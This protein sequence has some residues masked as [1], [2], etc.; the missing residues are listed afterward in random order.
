MK[1]NELV[2]PTCG[3]KCL[4][5]ASYTTCD[6]CQTFF[7]ASQ[8]AGVKLPVKVD[9]VWPGGPF[10]QETPVQPLVNQPWTGTPYPYKSFTMGTGQLV[11][12]QDDYQ[13]WN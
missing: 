3:L 13:I 4:T 10:V 2:C 1:L 5:E 6:S 8:S 11:N 12:S 9:I 7:Y